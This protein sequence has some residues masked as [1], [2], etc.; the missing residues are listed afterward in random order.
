MLLFVSQ[1]Q[2]LYP[3]LAEFEKERGW[4]CGQSFISWRSKCY[5]DPKTGK[6]KYQTITNPKTGRKRK[7]KIG[8][9]YKE[10][11][12]QRKEAIKKQGKGEKLTTT[13]KRYI[14]DTKR[15]A[16]STRK[17]KQRRAD[18]KQKR[19]QE[20]TPKVSVSQIATKSA[21]TNKRAVELAS[22]P[23]DKLTPEILKEI[24][25]LDM[26][27]KKAFVQ[28]KSALM[29]QEKTEKET[30]SGKNVDKQKVPQGLPDFIDDPSLPPRD[31]GRSTRNYDYIRKQLVTSEK[32]NPP[33][34]K[35]ELEQIIVD[36]DRELNTQNFIP[37]PFLN[38]KIPDIKKAD[39][40]KLLYQLQKD[41]DIDLTFSST[42]DFS[43]SEIDKGLRRSGRSANLYLSRT[44]KSLA[45]PIEPKNPSDTYTKPVPQGLPY[46]ID[47]PEFPLSGVGRSISGSEGR[48]YVMKHRRKLTSV[49][50]LKNPTSKEE[51]EKI[52]ADFDREIDANNFIPIP[53][54]N[55]KIPNMPAQDLHGL[56]RKLEKNGDVSLSSIV[57]SSLYS[58]SEKSRAIPQDVGGELFFVSRT[59]KSL[60][61][62]FGKSKKTFAKTEKKTQ[63]SLEKIKAKTKARKDKKQANL[64]RGKA[65]EIDKLIGK[66][67]AKIN[68]K[69]KVSNNRQISPQ[70][71]QPGGVRPSDEAMTIAKKNWEKY[72]KSVQSPKSVK[73]NIG[74][75][76]VQINQIKQGKGYASQPS[77]DVKL[78][79]TLNSK[80]P[81]YED[82]KITLE[83]GGEV[84]KGIL[85]GEYISGNSESKLRSESDRENANRFLKDNRLA[86]G[87]L[88]N[89]TVNP[90]DK[91]IQSSLEKIQAKT[92]A[93]K[94]K[95]AAIAKQQ[96]NT[97]KPLIPN[98]QGFLDTYKRIQEGNI[99]ADEIKQ[100]QLDLRANED[101]IKQDINKYPKKVLLKMAGWRAKLLNKKEL[102]VDESY[103]NLEQSLLPPGAGTLSYSYS[104]GENGAEE[105]R[106]N[107]R[108]AIDKQMELWTDDLIKDSAKERKQ[109]IAERE[110]AISDPKTIEDYR[111][112]IRYKGREGLTTAQR[113]KYEDLVTL[114]SR[115]DRKQ[116]TPKIQ[117]VELPAN[118]SFKLSQT[119]HTKQG[120]DLYVA[121]L[122][123]RVDRDKYNELNRRAKQLGGYYSRYSRDGAVP[124]FQF[125]DEESARK[126]MGLEETQ[127]RDRSSERQA[128][129]VGFLRATAQRIIERNEE[130]LNQPRLVNTARRARM[131]SGVEDDARGEIATAKTMLKIADAKDN[132][133]IQFLDK[134]SAATE[135][136]HLESILWRSL[137]KASRDIAEKKYPDSDDWYK[138]KQLKE[139]IEKEGITDDTIEYA[140]YPYPAIHKDNLREILEQSQTQKGLKLLS[141]R[142][143]KK[144]KAIANKDRE[145]RVKF[146]KPSDIE[147]LRRLLNANYSGTTKYAIDNAKEELRDYDRIHTKLDLKTPYELRA[148]LREFNR[149]RTEKE[150]EDPI[151]AKERALIGRKIEG[152]FPT[153]KPLVDKMIEL[154]DLK[155]GQKVLEPSAGS[156]NIAEA[157]REKVGND[158][159]S[160]I[161]I[162]RDLSSILDDKGFNNRRD[163]FLNI[164]DESYDKIIQNPP[165]ESLED[166]DHVK[167][168][169][170]LLAPGGTLVS[171]MSESPFFQQQK[172]AREFREWLADKDGYS[173]KNPAGSFKDSER[174]TGVNTRIVVIE[175]PYEKSTVK[176]S[177]FYPKTVNFS[178]SYSRTSI[179]GKRHLVRKN[180]RKK[181]LLTT[182]TGLGVLGAIAV[183]GARKGKVRVKSS[184][185]SIPNKRPKL[186]ASEGESGYLD[187]IAR[188]SKRG[189]NIIPPPK[190]EFIE[191]LNQV[192]RK[193][194]KDNIYSDKKKFVD[195]FF[196]AFKIPGI[197]GKSRDFYNLVGE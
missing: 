5:K 51:L 52:I 105:T 42:E 127:G 112:I 44:E 166:V 84:Y 57:D 97:T 80:K 165:F 58:S 187:G 137:Y 47:D 9:D 14:A 92:K 68:P 71:Q 172:K 189:L 135:V 75:E 141:N 115:G 10:Y 103:D 22:L 2:A 176:Y 50:K 55:A 110:K 4:R 45:K 177:A 175:K 188:K 82:K 129:S 86:I 173:E 167:K 119:K 87:K 153:P 113:A 78:K 34:T 121:S 46:F 169:Y 89:S 62:D 13:E 69:V 158:T 194:K 18:A 150:S 134:V 64:A 196:K 32:L 90:E 91:P 8:L 41:D 197:Y 100:A 185:P 85:S 79:F 81:G 17:K 29:R 49:E 6:V 53:F 36:L 191:E 146:E 192:W 183:I 28:Q 43:D 117:A 101:Q 164:T 76:T 65:V 94:D 35:Q 157:I 156:G 120:H 152:Y 180:R 73:A 148:A 11:Q 70:Q 93:R 111:T 122:T 174:S 27:G 24:T 96:E 48:D 31:G 60:S 168:A 186:L 66:Q 130:K 63:S 140:E 26:A 162:D 171:V 114:K 163:N 72:Q 132:N 179:K 178:N 145:W 126:F 149:L 144:Y 108:K 139:K 195:D 74:G 181:I 21:Q 20:A 138:R 1:F 125:R 23:E 33:K 83:G 77:Y 155:P 19:K 38:A 161:E 131:A 123:E 15:L 95:K 116:E 56:L 160:T 133:A 143:G 37:I 107:R 61:K 190:R 182:V 54:L 3:T 99:T 102:L 59:E 25:S 170:D 104:F 7:V 106:N 154:A 16:E 88:V 12:K 128:K 67:E 193:A 30:K 151:K 159:V 147:D 39:F 136:N 142:I 118:K 109:A 184:K 124:G 40:D 98:Y